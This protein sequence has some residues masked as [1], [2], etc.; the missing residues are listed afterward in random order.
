MSV[1]VILSRL[2]LIPGSGST[3][4]GYRISVVRG[5]LMRVNLIL[6]GLRCIPGHLVGAAPTPA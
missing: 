4:A 2:R 3:I 1:N 5:P 6:S